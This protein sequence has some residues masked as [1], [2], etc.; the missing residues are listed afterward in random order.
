[1]PYPRILFENE[2]FVVLYKPCAVEMHDPENGIIP[3]T[4]LTLKTESP[5]Y[6]VHRLDKQT[7]GLLLLAKTKVAAAELGDQFAKRAVKKLYIA[8]ASGKPKKKQGKIN[9]DMSKA[10]NGSYKLSSSMV[11]PALTQFYTESFALNVRLYKLKPYTG[12]THQLRVALKSNSTPILGDTRYSG[13]AADRMYLHAC[14]LNFVSQG[15][16]HT[17]FSSPVE[18]K[19]WQDK[20]THNDIKQW[21]ALPWPKVNMQSLL[22]TSHDDKH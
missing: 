6:L 19:L 16:A 12:K 11:N 3:L 20:F 22:N 9:G 2:D 15:Q 1:M 7:S 18:G 10:R 5:L 21:L 17:F 14:Y 4:R 8:L 13:D